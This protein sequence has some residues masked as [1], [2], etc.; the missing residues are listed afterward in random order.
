MQKNNAGKSAKRQIS[1]QG[2]YLTPAEI[3]A[4]RLALASEMVALVL[5]EPDALPA[6]AQDALVHM[7]Q[8]LGALVRAARG[9]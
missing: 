9:G 2:H 7:A 6:P 8:A 5:R 3:Q 1:E 4:R